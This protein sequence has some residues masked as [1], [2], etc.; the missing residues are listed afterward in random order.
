M[1]LADARACAVVMARRPGAAAAKTRLA[2]RLD[3]TARSALYE[4]FLR[5]KLTALTRVPN[6]A[7]VVAVA[8]PDDPPSLAPF[9]PI[10]TTFIAQRGDDLGARLR[11]V[12]EDLF[13]RGARAVVLCDSDSP[14]LPPHFV[15]E[16]VRALESGAVDVVIGPAADG[17]Y[18][19]LGTTRAIPELFDGI[20]WS[21]SAVLRETLAVAD[22]LQLRMHLLPSWFDVDVP[23]DLDRLVR[24]LAAASPYAPAYPAATAHVLRDLVAKARERPRDE[25]WKTRSLRGTYQNRW[26]SVTERVVTL[27]SGHVTLYGVVE[28]A[29]CVGVLP[30]LPNGDVILVRQFRYVARR[31]TWEMP[32]GG[33]HPHESLAEA[34]HRELREEAGVVAKTLTRIAGFDTSKSV[35][36]EHA[37]LFVAEV[38]GIGPNHGA[39]AEPDPTEEIERR[40]FG[41]AEV[42]RMIE[43]GEITDS[44]TVIALLL[45]TPA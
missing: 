33:A 42:R 4:A 32:T 27:P 11:A 12:S 37:H 15:D 44:M 14:T 9:A 2:S 29:P 24:E 35:V 13:A 8:P 31:F 26:M 40:V 36:D 34:A 16:A 30:V 7:C 19:L 6:L 21:T 17:G 23:A 10:G 18:T 38:E 22:R 25:H 45:T 39:D 20:A 43:A 3:E 1:S 5:D 28:T 41:R